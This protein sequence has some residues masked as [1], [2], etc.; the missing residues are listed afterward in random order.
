MLNTPKD[1]LFDLIKSL[2]KSEKRNF[3]LFARRLQSGESAKFMLLFDALGKQKVYE[4]AKILKRLPQIKRSQ[5]S[6]LKAHLNKQLLISLRLQH[7]PN[8][9]DMQIRERMDYAKILYNKGLYKQ[10]LKE[11]DRVKQVALDTEEYLLCYEIIEFEKLIE[12][13]YITRSIKSRSDDLVKQ[14]VTL[15]HKT[16]R[17]HQL[18][19]LA[20]KL[21]G[22]YINIG[23]VRNKEDRAKVK[24]FFHT[25]LPNNLSE[26]QLG[27]R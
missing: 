2:T 22:W 14:A 8:N 17:I 23:S 5:L 20:L 1:P 9:I 3:K 19:N 16:I 12:S 6:N 4:E 21:Y 26:Q 27:F 11:L 15:S 10:S 25:N 7:T 13:Q 24:T 18:S